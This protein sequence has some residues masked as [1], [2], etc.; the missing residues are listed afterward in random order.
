VSRP[1]PPSP[2]QP[3]PLR[4]RIHFCTQS[5]KMSTH[6]CNRNTCAESSAY[7]LRRQPHTS[8]V[9]T[10]LS[11]SPLVVRTHVYTHKRAAQTCTC[12][13]SRHGHSDS[14]PGPHEHTDACWVIQTR[15]APTACSFGHML[16][17]ISGVYAK[18]TTNYIVNYYTEEKK[19]THVLVGSFLHGLT[20]LVLFCIRLCVCPHLFLFAGTTKR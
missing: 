19:L 14:R 5:K 20:I 17:P 16:F 7:G 12:W 18:S 13:P 1:P 15:R 10:Q 3:I 11:G 8:S 4:V 2:P 6:K 9:M